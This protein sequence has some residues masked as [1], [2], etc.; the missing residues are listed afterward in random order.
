MGSKMGVA[1]DLSLL[2]GKIFANVRRRYSFICHFRLLKPVFGDVV[3]ER[4][5]SRARTSA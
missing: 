3:K 4:L 1:I 5:L 2:F